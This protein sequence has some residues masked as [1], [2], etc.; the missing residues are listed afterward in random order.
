MKR[1]GS[2]WRRCCVCTCAFFFSSRRRHTRCALLT[3]VQT[4]ALPISVGRARVEL[5]QMALLTQPGPAI[6]QQVVVYR[7]VRLV[8]DRAILSNRLMLPKERDALF[9]MASVTG[10]VERRRDHQPR[11]AAPARIVAHAAPGAAFQAREVC[12]AH[13][14]ARAC[15]YV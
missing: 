11:A 3:G 5:R 2:I 12:T 14:R 8:A 9:G 15:Q 7:A 4:C 10:L 13:D 1:L 6:D